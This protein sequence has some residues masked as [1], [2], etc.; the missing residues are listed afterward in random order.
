MGI[1]VLCRNE[2]EKLYIFRQV[3]KYDKE[4]CSECLRKKTKQNLY[5]YGCS[6]DLTPDETY[7]KST[8]W[9]DEWFCKD[10]ILMMFPVKRC[11]R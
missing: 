5:C 3:G 2:V 11:E 6:K 1:C 9:S 4:L 10:C 7:V 8:G